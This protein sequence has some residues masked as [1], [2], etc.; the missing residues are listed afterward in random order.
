MLS[1]RLYFNFNYTLFLIDRIQT[2]S[3]DADAIK[4]FKQLYYFEY[5]LPD[6]NCNLKVAQC[7]L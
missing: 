5:D 6:F 1:S 3:Y 7:Y 4:S 2:V